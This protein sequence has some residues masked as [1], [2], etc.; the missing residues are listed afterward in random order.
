MPVNWDSL[1]IVLQPEQVFQILGIGKNVG[2]ALLRQEDFPK[3]QVGRRFKIP[4]DGLRYWLE[5]RVKKTA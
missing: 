4:R 5:S 2:Y 1:P 3:V